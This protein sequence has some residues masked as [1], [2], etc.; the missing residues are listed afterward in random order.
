MWTRVRR[1]L[2]KDMQAEVATL[3]KNKL[4]GTQSDYELPQTITSG[5]LACPRPN[6]V[7]RGTRI[8]L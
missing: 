5:S 7:A 3:S 1:Y 6:I 4:C 8:V 2:L